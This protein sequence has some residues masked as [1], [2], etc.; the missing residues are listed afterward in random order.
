MRRLRRAALAAVA[1]VL[2]VLGWP[3]DVTAQPLA[4][5]VVEEIL[6]GSELFIQLRQAHL[7]EK[8]IAPELVRTQNSRGQLAFSSGAAGRL[9]RFSHLRLGSSCFLLSRGQI[10]VSGKQNGCTRSSRMSARGTNYVIALADSGEAEL[11]VLEGT[12]DVQSLR[13]GQPSGESPITLTSGQK[14]RFS[15]LGLPLSLQ[16]LTEADYA[17]ILRGPLFQGFNAPLPGMTALQSYLQRTYPGLSPAG[18]QPTA[19][20]ISSD[21]LVVSINLARERS[22]R[23]VL[24]PLPPALAAENATYLE[25]V[26]EGILTSS[27]C[28]HDRPLWDAFQSRM[29]ATMKLM[30]TSEVIACPMPARDW[31]T[32]AIVSRWMTSPLHTQILIN[33]PRARHIDCVRLVKAGR[34]VGM[35]TLWTPLGGFGQ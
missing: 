3:T 4:S 5:A 35:C 32:E 30:P 11:V 29:A 17:A 9:N 22:G 33:R 14:V 27:N 31:N 7:H 26:L 18:G 19:P 13:D 21:P 15:P 23:P 10:L 2:P 20:V 28:D 12:V 6:D 24:Q 8:A 1:A 16:R 25:P 34:A